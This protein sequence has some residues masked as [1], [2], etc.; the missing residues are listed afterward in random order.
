MTK[1]YVALIRKDKNTDF[2]IDIPDFP[3]C[4]SNG[5]SIEEAKGVLLGSDQRIL[6]IFV[7]ITY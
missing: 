4:V 7:L 1:K 2:W 6:L 5:E 3:G